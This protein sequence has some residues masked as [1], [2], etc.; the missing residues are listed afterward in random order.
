MHH[1]RVALAALL[2]LAGL[3][4]TACAPG[5]FIT[6]YRPSRY[7]LGA[8]RRVAVL[9]IAGPP[10]SVGVVM[11]ELQQQM[12]HDAYYQVFNAMP[13]HVTLTILPGVTLV[14]NIGAVR[15]S[16]PADVYIAAEVSRWQYSE[17]E[18]V[19]DSTQNGVKIRKLY[20]V[21][22]GRV[23]IN[24]QVVHGANGKLVV[25]QEYFRDFEAQ[26]YDPYTGKRPYEADVIRSAA[27][28]AVDHFLNDITPATVT[29]KIVLD[30]DE[31]TLKPGIE[32]CKNGALDAAMASFQ[33]V[34][35]TNPNSPGATYNI[36]V[37]LEARGEYQ[38]AEDA[39]R[40]ASGLKKKSLYEDALEEM[41]RR[42]ADEQ[43]LQQQL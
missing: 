27:A 32:L 17:R 6:R 33:E 34:L 7:N 8:T 38:Q 18:L 22:Q 15:A 39:Y 11:A 28:E 40:K 25:M 1:R 30:N 10:E 26:K 2:A 24:F 13:Q 29:D 41:H 35:K 4:L 36:G 12:V 14:P 21:P 5:I 19:E 37:L 23:G 43:S 42:V 9:S 31:D 16:V 20:R 3:T